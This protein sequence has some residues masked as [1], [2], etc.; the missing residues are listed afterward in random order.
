[1]TREMKHFERSSQKGQ[2]LNPK[3]YFNQFYF[4]WSYNVKKMLPENFFIVKF[5]LNKIMKLEK[6]MR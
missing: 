4:L 3:N 1:M 5:C 6:K 2:S